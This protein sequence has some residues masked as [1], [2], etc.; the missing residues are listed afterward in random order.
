MKKLIIFTLAASVLPS[1]FGATQYNQTITAIYGTGN[2]DTRAGRRRPGPEWRWT[3]ALRGVGE[4]D[5]NYPQYRGHLYFPYGLRR[6]AIFLGCNLGHCVFRRIPGS[7]LWLR[8]II[9]GWTFATT[10][11]GVT[12][13]TIQCHF[14]ADG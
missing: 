4:E 2:T 9:T 7:L 3:L 5:G 13:M 12:T 1:V 11:G 6:S 8:L 10:P 14:R